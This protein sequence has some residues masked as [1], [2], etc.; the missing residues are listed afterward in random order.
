MATDLTPEQLEAE[1]LRLP[2]EPRLR[3]FERLLRSFEE[4]AELDDEV[5]RAWLDEAER[6]DRA[7]DEGTLAERPADE[8]FSRLRFPGFQ[9]CS[10]REEFVDAPASFPPAEE[11]FQRR[12]E[13]VS[14]LTSLFPGSRASFR[15]SKLESS[16]ASLLGPGRVCG[17]QIKLSPA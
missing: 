5:A 1:A 12:R 14:A 11:V 17:S 6:R 3:L 15:P 9:T 16:R 8:V 7:I 13:S 10:R 4:G 2:E